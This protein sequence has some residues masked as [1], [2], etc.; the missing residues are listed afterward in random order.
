M[1]SGF[2]LQICTSF[3][4]CVGGL[5]DNPQVQGLLERLTEPRKIAILLVMVYYSE[6]IH[7][8]IS[9]GKRHMESSGETR[10]KFPVVL[11]H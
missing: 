9:E 10:H 2:Y 7:T 6:R 8:K 4:V 3:G 5:E 11:I 1:L